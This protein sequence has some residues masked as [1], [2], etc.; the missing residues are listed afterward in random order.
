MLKAAPNR[1]NLRVSKLNSHKCQ[2]GSQN[3]VSVDQV[4]TRKITQAGEIQ[5]KH[6]RCQVTWKASITRST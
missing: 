4:I 3:Q 6:M 5:S 2:E 1:Q